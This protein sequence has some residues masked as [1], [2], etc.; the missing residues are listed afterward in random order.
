MGVIQ[1]KLMISKKL[2]EARG[3]MLGSSKEEG[4]GGG[5]VCGRQSCHQAVLSFS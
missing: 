3:M 4:A 5:R 1:E 2:A